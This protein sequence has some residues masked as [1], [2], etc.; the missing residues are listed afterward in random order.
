MTTFVVK[1][2]GQAVLLAFGAITI[3]F[4][5]VRV[6]PGDP[7]TLI[8]GPDASPEQLDQVR[9]DLG[10][11]DP[12]LQQYISHLG[13]VLTGD[14]GDSWRLGGSALGNT[15]DRF[16]ATLTLAALAL[17][18]TVVAGFP[19]G[20]AAARR[21]GGALDGL[22]STTS[23]VG[24][25]V[26]SFWLGIVLIL[27]FARELNWLPSTAGGGPAAAILPAVTL[28]LPFVGWLARLVRNTTLDESSRGYVRT[29]RSKGV[30]E[31]AVYYV[32]IGRNIMIPVV[33]VLGLLTG[34]FIA[35][36]V[37]VEV[38][39]SWQGIGSLMVDAIVNRDYAVVE[40]ATLTIT[41]SYILL[42]LIVDV[43]YFRLDP[44]LTPENA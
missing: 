8:L 37:I 17:L 41:L 36:A 9:Q 22:I 14:V 3:V 7:A 29:A 34:N 27:V 23:L 18:V 11:D 42:N 25:G 43:L 20:V 40:A 5:V 44:R 39:F 35:N 24:Q 32:H 28:A 12:L 33:T 4:F 15:L 26:P 2:L 6:V 19:L 13:S 16:P 10:L 31:L 30:P 21:A 1:R 38:V